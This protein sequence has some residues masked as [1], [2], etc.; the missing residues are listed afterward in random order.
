VLSA[1]HY[2][3]SGRS[4]GGL[5]GFAV[6][7]QDFAEYAYREVDDDRLQGWLLAHR[8]AVRLPSHRALGVGALSM[9]VTPAPPD[10]LTR[11]SELLSSPRSLIR[12]SA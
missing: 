1:L 6:M 12:T 4:F 5:W 10:T 3:S 9:R 7:N 2:S 8:H 11:R